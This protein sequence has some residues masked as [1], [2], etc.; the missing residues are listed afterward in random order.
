M[1]Q[2]QHIAYRTPK[3]LVRRFR[4][5]RGFAAH[6]LATF[7]HIVCTKIFDIREENSGDLTVYD[8]LSS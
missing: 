1:L 3:D 8:L 4:I 2:F 6:L 5:V 7:F